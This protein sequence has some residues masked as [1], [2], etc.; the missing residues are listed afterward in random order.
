MNILPFVR[1]THPQYL[2]L[3]LYLA[4]E[5]NSSSTKW[6]KLPCASSTSN[7]P[8]SVAN[9]TIHTICWWSSSSSSD[10]NHILLAFKK[11]KNQFYRKTATNA[12]TLRTLSTIIYE[13]KKIQKKIIE[14]FCKH[15]SS[16]LDFRSASFFNW[17]CTGGLHK[18]SLNIKRTSGLLQLLKSFK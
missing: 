14:L 12:A 13:Q 10:W 6:P 1:S 16:E 3:R 18:E 11:K 4:L 9:V 8:G 5:L 17:H 7:H 2:G 15:D